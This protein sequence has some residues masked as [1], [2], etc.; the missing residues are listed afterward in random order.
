MT[1]AARAAVDLSALRHNL[2]VAQ[3]ASPRSKVFAVAKANGYGHGLQQVVRALRDQA[4]GFAVSC[5]EEAVPVREAGVTKPVLLLEGFFEAKELALVD[6]YGLE[7]VV[8]SPWQV[9]MLERIRLERPLRVWLKVDSGMHRLGLPPARVAEIYRRLQALQWVGRLAFLTH[10]ACADD[11][12]ADYT[13]HQLATFER[14]CAGL[15]GERSIANSAGLLAWPESRADWV[16]PGIMLYGASPFADALPERPPLR[17][18]MTLSSVL[19]AAQRFRR[20]DPIGYAG[21][22]VCPEDM[23]V[24]VVAMGYGDGYPRHASTGTPVHVGGRR[25]C[26]LG[27]VSMDMLCIDLRGLDH[28]RIGDRVTLWGEGLPVEEVAQA[29]GTIS[30]EL[31]C[32]LTRR[33]HFEYRD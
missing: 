12:G 25:T 9:E 19:I 31:L 22:F 33:V 18:A 21:A 27:R 3:T 16:R 15:P 10:L 32:K 13:R 30:Y 11:R 20:G 7:V 23:P 1:R 4:D 8:H 14:A 17:P 29:C 2:S 26:V 5:L 28:V 6:R 24:G